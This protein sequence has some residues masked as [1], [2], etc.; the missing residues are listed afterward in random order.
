MEKTLFHHERE[1]TRRREA[2]FI[3]FAEKIR[4]VFIETVVYVTGGFRTAK[5]MVNA[6][7]SGATDGIGLGRPITAEPACTSEVHNNGPAE[8]LLYHK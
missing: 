6:I 4:P 1:S 7:R 3:E 2:F 5:G 8:T